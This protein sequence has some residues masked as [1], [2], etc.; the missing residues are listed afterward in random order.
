MEKVNYCQVNK[1]EVENWLEIVMK[2]KIM[3]M[4]KILKEIE[5]NG[6]KDVK[7]RQQD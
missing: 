4:V 5:E 1:Y 3:L 2:R 6:V 7:G